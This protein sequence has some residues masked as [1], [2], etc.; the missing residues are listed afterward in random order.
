MHLESVFPTV[1]G[2][3]HC[4]FFN[5]IK[6]DYI[7]IIKDIPKTTKEGDI[8]YQFHKDN[9]FSKL[10]NWI[11]ESVNDYTI[12]HKYPDNYL[13]GESW[14]I[15]YNEGYGQSFHAHTGWVVSTIFYL[16]SDENEANTIFRSPYYNDMQ[17]PL[18]LGPKN[19]TDVN[20]YN[21]YTYRTYQV[22][23]TEGLLL[24]FRSYLEHAAE[25]KRSK[26]VNRIVMSYNF[27]KEKYI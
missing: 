5:E 9:R 14:A 10:N 22:K 25:E 18:G 27:Q 3:N 15:D 2:F 16:Q 19:S 13:P 6:D 7:S 11:T 8:Y 12:K 20:F 26:K 1:I 24:V 4:P 21:E 23:P 17:N